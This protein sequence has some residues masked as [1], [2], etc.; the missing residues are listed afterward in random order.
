MQSRS[1]GSLSELLA[2]LLT[3]VR[4]RM[5]LQQK[6]RSLT[7]EGRVQAAVLIVLPTVAF[8]AISVLSPHYIACL[9]ER[10][11]V[12]AGSYRE[13]AGAVWIRRIVNIAY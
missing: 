2:N 4:K 5:K 7:S 10:P 12:L 1:G 13:V 3:L 9:L 11:Y 8:A 6:V